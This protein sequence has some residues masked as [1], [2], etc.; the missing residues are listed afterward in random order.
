MS[1]A[2]VL[3]IASGIITLL[4]ATAKLYR[5]ANDVS[6][7]P[8]SLAD[9]AARLPL[10]QRALVRVHDTLLREEDP[11]PEDRLALARALEACRAKAAAL[12]AVFQA[13][14]PSPGAS[15]VERYRKA[16]HAVS[17]ADR[18]TGL[19]EGMLADLQLMTGMRV[20]R[21]EEAE[22]K[23]TRVVRQKSFSTATVFA[24]TG[25]GSQYVHEG[26]GSQ[27]INFGHGPQFH[28]PITGSLY[29]TPQP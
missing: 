7:L 6:G 14:V 13:V 23:E 12:E 5:A 18:A 29:F 26:D 15:R 11:R 24:N 22:E 17:R 16:L 27:N 4:E 19:M 21:T 10:V 8:A 2:E 28:G 9:V 20:F 25:P 1:G 3:G